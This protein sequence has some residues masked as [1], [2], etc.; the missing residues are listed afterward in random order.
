MST[1]TKPFTKPLIVRYV[2]EENKKAIWE[3][4]ESF[5]YYIGSLDSEDYIE[6][7]AGF[8][9]DFATIPKAL[10]SIFPP[11]GKY[12]KA[13]VIH[14]YLTSNKGQVKISEKER[15]FS[16]KEVDDI[17][18]EAMGVLGVSYFVKKMVYLSVRVFGN[19][20]GYKK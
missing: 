1:F 14:D 20:T 8:Q 17:F 3:I 18:Y 6:V 15:F 12:V 5:V 10:W 4:Q 16:K 2:G 13:A 19:T 11:S 7:P 9:T